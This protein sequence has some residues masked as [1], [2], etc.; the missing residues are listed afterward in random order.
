[1][2]RRQANGFSIVTTV[3]A[4]AIFLCVFVALMDAW[5][6]QA[7]SV[8]LGRDL[9]A[10]TACAEREMEATV[11]AGYAAAVNRSGTDRVSHSTN[12]VTGITELTWTV[13][14]STEPDTTKS[15]HVQ[16]QWSEG[17]VNRVVRMHTI[18]VPSS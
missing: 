14:V 3:M 10:A 17:Q 15:V 4:T 6:L 2:R 16:V 9:L 1:M 18:L 12:D 5:P 11:A 7:R 8:A 13:T